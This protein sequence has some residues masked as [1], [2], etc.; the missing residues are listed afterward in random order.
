MTDETAIDE[1]VEET[2]EEK[3]AKAVSEIRKDFIKRLFA[4]AVS[5]GFAATLIN[6]DWITKAHWPDDAEQN[7]IAIL[8]TGLIA[9]IGSWDGYF[10]ALEKAPLENFGRFIIDITLVFL[11]MILLVTSY[12]H[13]LWVPLL[14]LIY[15]FYLA[16]DF[17]SILEHKS[18]FFKEKDQ[19]EGETNFTVVR[20]VYFDGLFAKEGVNKGPAVTLVWA[21]FFFIEVVLFYVFKSP[22]IIGL[23]IINI[24]ALV[25]YRVAKAD[26]QDLLRHE[27]YM[28][29]LIILTVLMLSCFKMV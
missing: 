9:T 2:E 25:L 17:V 5:I 10:R 23:A 3:E 1:K 4:V 16:W 24:I 12:N 20:R 22:N 15:V 18:K 26:R 29:A 28:P 21:L 6:M 14:G 8:L 11:Y 19:Y 7:Q 13:H 27:R